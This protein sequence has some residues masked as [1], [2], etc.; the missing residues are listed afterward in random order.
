VSSFTSAPPAG[1]RSHGVRHRTTPPLYPSPRDGP[2]IPRIELSRRAPPE[3]ITAATIAIT[4]DR[5]ARTVLPRLIC[6]LAARADFCTD[7][8]SD[9]QLLADT[10]A[11]QASQSI[12]GS[13][14]HVGIAVEPRQVEL[15]V[16]PLPAVRTHG[17]AVDAVLGELAPVIGRL[18]DDHSLAP[19]GPPS[20]SPYS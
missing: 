6:A 16:G 9:A 10:I 18:A 8:L 1:P 5:L 14:L 20:C 2:E 13:H 3:L 12:L 11:A 4:P 19:V 7:R 15:R 17:T